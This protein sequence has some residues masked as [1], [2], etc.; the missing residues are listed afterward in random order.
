VAFTVANTGQDHGYMCCCQPNR[1]NP[2]STC[3]QASKVYVEHR[4]LSIFV[5][6]QHLIR[7]L[8]Y[9][10]ALPASATNE[11]RQSRM[12]VRIW[13]ANSMM[14]SFLKDKCDASRFQPMN[15]F[16]QKGVLV[17][18]WCRRLRKW[19]TDMDRCSLIEM[20]FVPSS[21]SVFRLR[22]KV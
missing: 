3:S 21:N 14:R 5:L 16:H 11:T 8:L 6:A 18:C 7:L 15:G 22:K 10:F 13:A 2:S 9:W 1:A 17:C 4:V 19:C 12:M 20:H